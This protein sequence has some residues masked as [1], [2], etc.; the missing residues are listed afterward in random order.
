MSSDQ[1]KAGGQRSIELHI[2]ELVLHGFSA[3][4]RNRIAD[5]LRVELTRLLTEESA[6]LP[7][8]ADRMDTGIESLDAGTVRV[9][10]ESRSG[11][12][13]GQ[14]AQALFGGLARGTARPEPASR[15]QSLEGSAPATEGAATK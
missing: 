2:E 13:G 7:I 9:I 14:I 5:A 10:S 11:V 8:A 15:P 6:S 3:G 12:I 4:D 1:K